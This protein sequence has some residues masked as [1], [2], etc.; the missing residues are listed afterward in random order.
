MLICLV[1]AWFLNL[2]RTVWFDP[3]NRE[4]LLSLRFF[5]SKNPSI[6]KKY[7]ITRTAIGQYGSQIRG[8]FSR[9]ARFVLFQSIPAEI[10]IFSGNTLRFYSDLEPK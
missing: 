1:K 3:I 8:Q 7:G 4:P 6:P 10:E 5:Y 9:F 2:D